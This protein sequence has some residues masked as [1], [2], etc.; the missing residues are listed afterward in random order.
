MSNDVA[1][2]WLSDH[3]PREKPDSSHWSGKCQQKCVYRQG[4]PLACNT[5]ANQ[6]EKIAQMAN[7]SSAASQE[8][9]TTAQHLDEAVA[10]MNKAIGRYRI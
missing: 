10:A 3:V 2:V 5:I 1:Q 9:A 6:V 4:H 8:T 7:Q